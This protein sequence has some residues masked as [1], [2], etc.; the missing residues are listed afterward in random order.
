MNF[1][2]LRCYISITRSNLEIKFRSGIFTFKMT[3]AFPMNKCVVIT[4]KEIFA[5]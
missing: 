4:M 1:L 3:D 2:I 5:E